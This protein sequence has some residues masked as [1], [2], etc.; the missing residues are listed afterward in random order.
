LTRNFVGIAGGSGAG[1]STLAKKLFD[2]LDGAQN[3]TYLVHDSYYR[4]LSD[5]A[6]SEREA[7][8]FDHPDSLETELMVQ[9][10]RDLKQGKIVE[11]PVYD[12]TTHTRVCRKKSVELHGPRPI[13]LIEGILILCTELVEE[14]DLKVFVVSAAAPNKGKLCLEL[15]FASFNLTVIVPLPFFQGCCAGYPLHSSHEPR[16]LRTRAHS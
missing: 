7:T 3:V 5:K 10:I 12:F 4:D 9:H 2:A 1:K 16:L 15:S 11:V 8:N 13:L 6:I 14:M